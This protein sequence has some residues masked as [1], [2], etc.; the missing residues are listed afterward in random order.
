MGRFYESMGKLGREMAKHHQ[1]LFELIAA[2]ELNEDAVHSEQAEIVEGHR[3]MQ[4]LVVENLLAD[5][6]VLTSEQQAKYFG[7][8]RQHCGATWRG[9]SNGGPGPGSGPSRKFGPQFG[10]TPGA[11]GK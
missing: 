6:A 4:E 7:Q 10:K 3:K 2:P 1:K 9:T 11:K 5:K 8:I